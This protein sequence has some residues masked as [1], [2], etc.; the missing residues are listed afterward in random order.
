VGLRRRIRKVQCWAVGDTG[1]VFVTQDG[2][3]RRPTGARCVQRTLLVLGSTDVVS[4]DHERSRLVCLG[5][6]H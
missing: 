1:D 4:L 3:D 6:D 2:V 5:R